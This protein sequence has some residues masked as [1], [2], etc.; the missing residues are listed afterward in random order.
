MGCEQC[1]AQSSSSRMQAQPPNRKGTSQQA[2]PEHRL[3]AETSSLPPRPHSVPSTLLRSLFQGPASWRRRDT[4][5]RHRARRWPPAAQRR[6]A[7]RTSR[8]SQRSSCCRQGPAR[9]HIPAGVVCQPRAREKR[10]ASPR[11]TTIATGSSDARAPSGARRRCAL[12]RAASRA[13]GLA[14]IWVSWTRTHSHCFAVLHAGVQA[15]D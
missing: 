13:S 3:S 12:L 9:A 11:R 5:G 15:P 10:I 4:R 6:A 7:A 14:D 1:R 8:I 2:R